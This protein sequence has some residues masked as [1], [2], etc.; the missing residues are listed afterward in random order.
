MGKSPLLTLA[1]IG[2]YYHDA[3]VYKKMMAHQN[4]CGKDTKILSSLM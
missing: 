3:F 2:L 1:H 4:Y